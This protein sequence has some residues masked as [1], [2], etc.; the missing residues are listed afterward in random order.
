VVLSPGYQLV[1]WM[2][3]DGGCD[4]LDNGQQPKCFAPGHVSFGYNDKHG[5]TSKQCIYTYPTPLVQSIPGGP[6]SVTFT[7][8]CADVSG[9]IC[10]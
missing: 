1:S 5:K 4:G 8:P 9:V 2:V 7:K 3:H 10:S 6:T